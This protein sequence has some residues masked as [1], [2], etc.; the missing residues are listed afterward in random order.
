[1]SFTYIMV[2]RWMGIHL[3]FIVLVFTLFTAIF[4]MFAKDKVDVEKLAFTLQIITDVV[5]FF[6][7]SIRMTAEIENYMTS[8]QRIHRYT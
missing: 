1:M 3:D 4:S 6:S 2:N 8:S 5:V 7:Y